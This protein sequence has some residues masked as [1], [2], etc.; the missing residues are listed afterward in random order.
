MNQDLAEKADLLVIGLFQDFTENKILEL[1][2]F[3]DQKDINIYFLLG[4][5]MSS[6]SWLVAK[7]FLR[8]KNVQQLPNGLFSHKKMNSYQDQTSWQILH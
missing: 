1:L 5:D 2:N 6:L 8:K 7:Q 4:R 3:A